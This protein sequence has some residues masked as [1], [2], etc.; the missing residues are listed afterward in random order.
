MV[1]IVKVMVF[2]LIM[3]ECESWTIRKTEHQRTDA[4][5][6]ILWP[7]DAKSLMLGKIEGRR[8]R[9]QEKMVGWYHQLKGHESEQT[10]GDSEG[11]G[12]VTWYSPWGC[13]V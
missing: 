4:E 2:P 12:S 5:A 6:P 7:S 10:P 8:R 11:Q 13:Q 3:Y 9:G 1:H